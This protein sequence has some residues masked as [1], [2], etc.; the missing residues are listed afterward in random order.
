[1]GKLVFRLPKNSN[2]QNNQI[3]IKISKIMDTLEIFKVLANEHRYQMLLWLKNPERHFPPHAC[4]PPGFHGGVRVGL[5]VEK[6]GLAQSVVSAYLDA[7]KK[8]NLVESKRAGRWTYYRYNK[9]FILQF[10]NDLDNNL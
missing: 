2:L 6:S 1:M 5:I 8:V 3:F 9:S 10:I 4:Q 7:L